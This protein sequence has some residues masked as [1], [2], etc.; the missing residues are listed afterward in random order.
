M[1][2]PPAAALVLTASLLGCSRPP[3]YEA[4]AYPDRSDLLDYRRLGTYPSLAE[5]RTAARAYLARLGAS[6]TGD[7][8]CGRECRPS[9]ID[10]NVWICKET[11]R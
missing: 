4:F 3:I 11:L 5:C 2:I 8:E 10:P 9:G 7:Y 6:D 1:R